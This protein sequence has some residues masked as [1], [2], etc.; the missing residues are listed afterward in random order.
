MPKDL[1]TEANDYRS[2][3]EN[4]QN[5]SFERMKTLEDYFAPEPPRGESYVI[6]SDSGSASEENSD[7]LISDH[8][9]S[10]AE[11]DLEV[12]LI[13]YL[14]HTFQITFAR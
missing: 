6:S 7:W 14:I 10:A 1:V 13:T 5:K 8:D 11:E 9:D 3:A 4:E 2:D 12:W